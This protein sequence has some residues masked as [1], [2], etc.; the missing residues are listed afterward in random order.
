M[1]Y[2]LPESIQT[3]VFARLP[4]RFRREGEIM[5][6][7]AARRG[8][9][10]VASFLEG[11]SFDRAGNLYV[12]DIP[13]GR[14][15]RISTDGEFDLAAEYDG[16]PN[17]LCIHSDGRVF[18]A[19][20]RRGIMTMDPA[21][22]T[23]QPHLPRRHTESFKGV[24]DLHFSSKGDLYFTDMGRTGYHDPTGAI[25]CLSSEGKLRK[26]L[27]TGLNSNGLVLNKAENVLYVAMTNANAIWHLTL[28]PDDDAISVGN[29]IQLS[30]GIGPDGM[31]LTVDGGLAVAHVGMG[32]V[33]IF[34]SRGE[35]LYRVISCGSD[36][37]TNIAFGGSEGRTLYIIDSGEGQILK[38]E[39][40]VAGASLF[41]H[42]PA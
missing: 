9:H 8:G 20:Y 19:D 11:P 26:L 32:C 13:F 30:G 29:F 17:G 39:L 24:N 41:A 27:G 2:P 42:R 7:S 28:T 38:A 3:E 1:Y 4:E 31:A 16:E 35:P 36:L 37:V 12:C 25:Y 33:W 6:W 18:I 14:I 15:F 40:P 21:T 22:G 10:P 23:V 5:P 34:N